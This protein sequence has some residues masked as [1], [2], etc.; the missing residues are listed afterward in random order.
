M[1]YHKFVANGEVMPIEFN[2]TIP[3]L[4][5]FSMEKAKEFYEQNPS[6]LKVESGQHFPAPESGDAQNSAVRIL[7]Y[8]SSLQRE[9]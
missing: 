4:R 8:P 1:A 9:F 6:E 7:R 3:I 2:R 5:I